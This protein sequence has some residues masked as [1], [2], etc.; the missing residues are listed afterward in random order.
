M[1]KITYEKNILDFNIKLVD[2]LKKNN[3]NIQFIYFSG[4]GIDKNTD[5]KRS[6]AIFK[7]EK[8]TLSLAMTVYQRRAPCTVVVVCCFL[9]SL[10]AEVQV[11]SS[12][13]MHI[14]CQKC[15]PSLAWLS[16]FYSA[17]S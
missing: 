1:K 10:K 14:V 12:P 15:V 16:T 2:T 9:L 4:I 13:S 7:S 6:K 5:S 8:Y 11:Q 3:K 17:M